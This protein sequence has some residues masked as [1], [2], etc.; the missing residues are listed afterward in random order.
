MSSLHRSLCAIAFL[1]AAASQAEGAV[2]LRVVGEVTSD[3]TLSVY[4]YMADGEISEED[5]LESDT[6]IGS[7]ILSTNGQEVAEVTVDF[8]ITDFVNSLPPGG[9]HWIGFN[10]R[11]TESDGSIVTIEYLVLGNF[12]SQAL[13]VGVAN[14]NNSMVTSVNTGPLPHDISN[15]PGTGET[16]GVVEIRGTQVPEPVSAVLWV[17]G[18]AGV[19]TARARRRWRK[20]G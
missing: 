19:I 5:F 10:L 16:R 14:V 18:A 11:E 13:V 20:A 12:L 2:I 7:A 6:F 1:F 15:P 9:E 4:G 17:L 8:D 3:K